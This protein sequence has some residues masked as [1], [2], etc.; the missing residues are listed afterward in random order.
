MSLGGA[1]GWRARAWPGEPR[2]RETRA[3]RT[4]EGR[5][6]K[7]T[8]CVIASSRPAL[9]PATQS[10]DGE[11]RRVE[12]AP[13]AGAGRGPSA[14]EI[15][16]AGVEVRDAVGVHAVAR[17]PERRCA[18]HEDERAQCGDQG[19]ELERSLQ[20]RTVRKFAARRR[21]LELAERKRARLSRAAPVPR[22]TGG[23]SPCSTDCRSVMQLRRDR[24]R[25][26]IAPLN[27]APSTGVGGTEPN[28]GEPEGGSRP[29][30]SPRPAFG[31]Q[32]LSQPATPVKSGMV[33][34]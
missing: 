31:P 3:P 22:L 32:L 28:P 5:R 7:F 8:A 34:S 11:Q 15:D 23:R 14:R 25:C 26:G 2:G 17:E 10:G 19:C 1:P 30:A 29:R 16:V 33:K 9:V 24:A 27:V 13:V 21:R 18:E 6:T 12:R 4:R 20:A